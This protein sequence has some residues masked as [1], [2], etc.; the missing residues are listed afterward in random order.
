ML[1]FGSF[2]LNIFFLLILRLGA[3]CSKDHKEKVLD[4]SEIL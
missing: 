2:I 4:R 1:F 3:Q